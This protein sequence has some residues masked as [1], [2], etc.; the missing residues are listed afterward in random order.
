MRVREQRT[1]VRGA[2]TLMEMLVVVAILVVLAGAA[3][4]L[5]MRYLEDAKRDTARIN[6]QTIAKT[7]ETYR[8]RFGEYP[9]SLAALVQQAP[10]GGAPYLEQDSLRDPWQREYQYAPDGPNNGGLKPDVWSLGANPNDPNQII[11]NWQ[12][13]G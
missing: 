13:K 11:G 4:P 10:D 7:C 2:F 9:A 5:Y 12:P 8:L 1:K 3:V 6:V